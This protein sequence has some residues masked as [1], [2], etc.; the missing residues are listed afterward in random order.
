M[1]ATDDPIELPPVDATDDK[2]L[3]DHASMKRLIGA[4][5][6]EIRTNVIEYG[7]DL[8]LTGDQI[9]DYLRKFNLL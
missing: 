8:G 3:R 5:R 2:N 7:Q 4:T 1:P 6:E 9:D